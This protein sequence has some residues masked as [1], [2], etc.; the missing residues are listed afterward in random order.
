MPRRRALTKLPLSQLSH[1]MEHPSFLVLRQIMS[2]STMIR[3]FTQVF[4]LREDLPMWT[5]S[6]L[7]LVLDSLLADM[8]P[9]WKKKR[10]VLVVPIRNKHRCQ[11]KISLLVAW[12]KSSMVLLEELLTW[13]VKHSQRW[14]KTAK[15]STRS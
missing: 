9:V 6:I 12:M 1:H 14:Q 8:T 11:F 2:N 5:I 15:F 3:V 10:K 13:M 4:M 7:L